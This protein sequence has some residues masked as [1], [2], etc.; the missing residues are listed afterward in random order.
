MVWALSCRNARISAYLHRAQETDDFVVLAVN[1]METPEQIQAYADELGL[2]F[3]IALDPNGD[4]NLLFDVLAYP[5]TYVLD[6][7]GIIRI[8]HAGPVNVAQVADWIVIASE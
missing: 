3:P 7:E 5:T 8:K 6:A 4:H 2:T 1:L